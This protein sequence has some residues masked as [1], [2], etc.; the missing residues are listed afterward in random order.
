MRCKDR[1]LFCVTTDVGVAAHFAIHREGFRLLNGVNTTHINAD[2]NSA[3][4]LEL[5]ADDLAHSRADH[6]EWISRETDDEGGKSSRLHSLLNE[7]GALFVLFTT[8]RFRQQT[9]GSLEHLRQIAHSYKDGNPQTISR[10]WTSNAADELAA[11]IQ[12][13]CADDVLK[14]DECCEFVLHS[15][16]CKKKPVESSAAIR[17]AAECA[18]QKNVFIKLLGAC[19]RRKRLQLSFK[20]RMDCRLHNQTNA[21]LPPTHSPAA[22]KS[23]GLGC[24]TNRS[25]NFVAMDRRSAGHFLRVWNTG[26]FLAAVSLHDD[27]V[28][29]TP[30]TGGIEEMDEFLVA[31][32]NSSLTPTVLDEEVRGSFFSSVSP[33]VAAEDEHEDELCTIERLTARSFRQ[34]ILN[35]T[36]RTFG[37]VVFFSGGG[38][39]GPSMSV[40][41][42]LQMVKR[43]FAAFDSLIRFFLIDVSRNSLPFAY[44]FDSL[45]ALMFFPAA[46]LP[47][48]QSSLFPQDLPLSG[49]QPDGLRALAGISP[50]SASARRLQLNAA[51]YLQNVLRLLQTHRS[52]DRVRLSAEQEAAIVGDSL[53]L[54]WLIANTFGGNFNAKHSLEL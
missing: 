24:R 11:S 27:A 33:E 30:L 52:D 53:L 20:Q 32:T 38:W 50:N 7:S 17:S 5:I 14:I 48:S 22:L 25:V 41:F 9:S 44:N 23:A 13:T 39:H 26:D 42:V 4:I 2:V 49:P 6:V 51:R 16:F 28:F 21:R 54:R 12:R 36:N 35:D 37:A 31:F 29:S 1:V 40:A 19:C 18:Q 10:P 47:Q 45:P 46:P 34:L 3:K 43:E 15:G 8:A